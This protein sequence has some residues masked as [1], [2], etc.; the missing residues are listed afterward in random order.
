M[1]SVKRVPWILATTGLLVGAIALLSTHPRVEAPPRSPVRRVY[2]ATA[3]DSE[4][5][6]AV[7]SLPRRVRRCLDG[8]IM[9]MIEPSKLPSLARAA[10]ELTAP[11]MLPGPFY[12]DETETTQ[13]KFDAFLGATGRLTQALWSHRLVAMTPNSAGLQAMTPKAYSAWMAWAYD[14]MDVAELPARQLTHGEAA[15][16]ATWVGCSLPTE[17]QFVYLLACDAAEGPYPWGAGLALD[18]PIANCADASFARAFSNATKMEPLLEYDDGFTACAPVAS[19]RP[20]SLGLYD[21]SGNVAEWC[22]ELVEAPPDDLLAGTATGHR[23]AVSRGGKW[24]GYPAATLRIDFREILYEPYGYSEGN[25]FRCVR[26]VDR[27][28]GEFIQD[29]SVR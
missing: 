27:R 7:W 20:N 25:G 23:F 19:F 15:A 9:V 24:V 13:G 16:Y 4:R 18:A 6:E 10:Q 11:S 22:R 14:G 8:S 29:L 3:L 17:A 5:V 1:T 21:V 28:T 12:A 26:S 2:W